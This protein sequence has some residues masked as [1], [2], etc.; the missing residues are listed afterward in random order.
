[1]TVCQLKELEEEWAKASA[2]RQSRFLRSQQDLQAKFKQ[3]QDGGDGEEDGEGTV[4][5]FVQRQFFRSDAY[6]YYF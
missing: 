6:Y 2:S 1:M 4:M 5:F 3:Q